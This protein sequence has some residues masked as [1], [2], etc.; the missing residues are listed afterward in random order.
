MGLGDVIAQTF[1]DGKQLTQ[2]NPMRTLQYSVVGL[3]V[4]SISPSKFK[5]NL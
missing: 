3:V 4:V 2:I 1:I 5:N